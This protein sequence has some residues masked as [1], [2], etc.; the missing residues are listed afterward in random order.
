MQHSNATSSSLGTFGSGVGLWFD[1]RLEKGRATDSDIFGST[2]LTP[3]E[4]FKIRKMEVWG[5]GW[6]QLKDQQ[7]VSG[8]VVEESRDFRDST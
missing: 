2:Q 4:N 7:V 8:L 6:K 5:L 3:R 1:E